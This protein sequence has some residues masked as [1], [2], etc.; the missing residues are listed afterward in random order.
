MYTIVPRMN[1]FISQ[2]LWQELDRLFKKRMLLSLGTYIFITIGIFGFW[3]VF[4]N[5]WIIPRIVS[6]FLIGLPLIFLLFCYFIQ[7]IINAWALYLRGH[8]QEPYVVSSIASGIWIVII[9]FLTGKYLSPA[10][11]FLGFLS[12]YVWGTPV[13]YIIYRK[14]KRMWHG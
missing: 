9:T 4:G 13:A 5:F 7:L 10:L 12:S 11:F 2:K 3:A 8:K 1:V 14:C 6:R